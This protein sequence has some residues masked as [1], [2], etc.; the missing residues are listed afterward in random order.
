MTPSQDLVAPR[1]P[2]GRGWR[3]GLLVVHVV[4]SGAWIGIDVIVAVLVSTGW[5]ADDLGLR[6]LAYRALAAFVVWPMLVSGL[7]CLGTGLLLGLGTKWGLIRYWWVFVKLVLNLLLCGL[8]VL[9]LQ[10]GM[11]DVAAYGE[12]LLTGS[13]PTS[14]TAR[15]FFPPAVS[16]SCLALAAV[17]AVFKPWGRVRGVLPRAV[18]R[19]RPRS[20]PHG[21][22]DAVRTAHR[23]AV[24]D[25]DGRNDELDTGPVDD[26]PVPAEEPL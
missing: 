18:R 4:S 26:R 6:S 22:D 15:L 13:S 20:Q 7:V 11:G 8:I 14:D 1:L 5:F 10:P 24:P 9:V 12:D 2:L 23:P 3:R 19:E 16:L 21:V 25:R 17:L